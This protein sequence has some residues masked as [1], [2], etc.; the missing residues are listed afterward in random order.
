MLRHL[1]HDNVLQLIGVMKQ[2][3]PLKYIFI[4][5]LC[6]KSL[7]RVIFDDP[8]NIPAQ[9]HNTKLAT[10]KYKR[11]AKEIANGLN[12]VHERGLVHRHLKLENVLVRM[13]FILHIKK[14][15]STLFCKNSLCT[16]KLAHF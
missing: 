15:I 6:K 1:K 11:W 7:R 14:C 16:H 4:M 2:D 3:D 12:Y 9:S 5:P 13:L 8:K 10:L